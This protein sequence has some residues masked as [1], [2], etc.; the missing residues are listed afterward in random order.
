MDWKIVDS[1]GTDHKSWATAIEAYLRDPSLR[2]REV[3]LHMG[4][5][6]TSGDITDI[7]AARATG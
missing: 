5:E 3:A 6:F 2:F 1:E 7:V 4:G